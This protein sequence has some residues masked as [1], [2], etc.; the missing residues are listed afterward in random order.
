MKTACFPLGD[1]PVE[2]DERAALAARFANVQSQV[3]SSPALAARETANWIAQAFDIDRA[4]DDLDY[5]HWRGHSVREIGAQ[6]PEEIAA[7]LA[8][9]HARPHGGESI[10]ML[11]ERVAQGLARLPRARGVVI[12][13]HAIV[14]K[15]AWAHVHGKPLS[16]IFAMGFAPLSSTVLDLDA[17]LRALP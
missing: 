12:V 14:V 13:T 2:H 6:R 11:A 16:E 15:A 8:D 4:F 17:E 5:G 9:P 1:E 10:A 3:I 7:W